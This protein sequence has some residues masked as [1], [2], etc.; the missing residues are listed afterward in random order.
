MKS[1]DGC[2]LTRWGEKK[3]RKKLTR[4][5]KKKK[6]LSRKAGKE[7]MKTDSCNNGLR[8][9][10]RRMNEID[11]EIKK[12]ESDLENATIIDKEGLPE[13]KVVV[14]SRVLLYFPE[15]KQE[16]EYLLGVNDPEHNV[17]SENTP[18]GRSIKGRGP[19]EK[20]DYRVNGR[21]Y[22]VEILDIIN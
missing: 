8:H 18:L 2:Y 15:E 22:S 21:T 3:C 13:D 17:I 7:R 10:I 6:K 9:L 14:G 4:L 1:G 11:R 5:K 19:G 12:I 16:V 20:V